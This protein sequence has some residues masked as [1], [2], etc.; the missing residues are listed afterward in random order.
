MRVK[1]FGLIII[2]SLLLHTNLFSNDE[3]KIAQIFKETHEKVQEILKSEKIKENRKQFAI[4][5]AQEAGKA[6]LS[7]IRSF[8]VQRQIFK[9]ADKIKEVIAKF[10]ATDF[11]AAALTEKPTKEIT[12]EKV[13]SDAP[14]IISND[15]FYENN[16]NYLNLDE[17]QRDLLEKK[18]IK[19]NSNGLSYLETDHFKISGN[20]KPDSLIRLALNYEWSAKIY[21]ELFRPTKKTPSSKMEI[22]IFKNLDSASVT[23]TQMNITLNNKFD[24]IE[25]FDH[26]NGSMWYFRE[27]YSRNMNYR[28]FRCLAK[29]YEEPFFDKNGSINALDNI[30]EHTPIPVIRK[31]IL[32]CFL[33]SQ[34]R[35][36]SMVNS[37][38]NDTETLKKDLVNGTKNNSIYFLTQLSALYFINK[39]DDENLRT[40]IVKE[41]QNYFR[42]PG[43]GALINILKQFLETELPLANDYCGNLVYGLKNKIHQYHALKENEDK[44]IIVDAKYAALPMAKYFK[45]LHYFY[46]NNS[47]ESTKNLL[48]LNENITKYPYINSMLAVN[49]ITLGK[50]AEA[51]KYKALALKEFPQDPIIK[52]HAEKF[53]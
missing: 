14:P 12:P 48:E 19:P 27:F 53:K 13:A 47:E 28:V 11:K 2:I 29:N 9:E 16:I 35:N 6:K 50:P 1:W 18:L 31:E 42:V 3:E 51:L 5:S 7:E 36:S 17:K 44:M 41:G 49:Y 30:A 15:S 40:L 37:I 21:L 8:Y 45:G 4:Q 52:L 46:S 22:F 32:F 38:L 23:L 39:N 33:M 20:V 10:E 43:R 34:N 25:Y 24:N 26:K